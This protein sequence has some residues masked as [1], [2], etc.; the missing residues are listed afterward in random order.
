MRMKE[1][2]SSLGNQ[3]ISVLGIF[4]EFFEA[5][6]IGKLWSW[7]LV[8]RLEGKLNKSNRTARIVNA[9]T[10]TPNSSAAFGNN[11]FHLWNGRERKMNIKGLSH[12]VITSW[13]SIYGTA[14]RSERRS[15][16]IRGQNSMLL[17]IWAPLICCV[18]SKFPLPLLRTGSDPFIS[19]VSGIS[20]LEHQLLVLVTWTIGND[21][22]SLATV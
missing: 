2:I 20:F 7:D 21:E 17:I 4:F 1:R 12:S 3:T 9:K 5:F 19:V 10:L 11:R 6:W 8:Q 16:Q 22:S 15:H 18:G 14:E 13:D